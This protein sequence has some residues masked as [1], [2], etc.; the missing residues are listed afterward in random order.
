MYLSW[1]KHFCKVSFKYGLDNHFTK[2]SRQ[3]LLTINYFLTD[4]QKAKDEDLSP[5][6][7]FKNWVTH[8]EDYSKRGVTETCV[9][10][11]LL[12]I[13]DLPSRWLHGGSNAHSDAVLWSHIWSILFIIPDDPSFVHLVVIFH[14][15]QWIKISLRRRKREGNEFLTP[16]WVR[17]P[18]QIS[19]NSHAF[20][21]PRTPK[22]GDWNVDPDAH[23]HM[24]CTPTKHQPHWVLI[25]MGYPFQSRGLRQCSFPDGLNL[26]FLCI[27]LWDCTLLPG[28][29]VPRY[30][31]GFLVPISHEDLTSKITSFISPSPGKPS[32]EYSWFSGWPAWAGKENPDPKRAWW[33]RTVT[34]RGVA[35]RGCHVRWILCEWHH[36]EL[37]SRSA[38]NGGP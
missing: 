35:G 5:I 15:K 13:R 18:F 4:S 23:S 33:H 17:I 9:I 25:R 32:L 31:S 12:E 28:P 27:L 16:I 7:T 3:L 34:Q 20:L 1:L 14:P 36:L 2:Y 29:V 21:P 19:A 8:P 11:A 24:N 6:R 22:P 38:V 37:C 10:A 26:S 30:S